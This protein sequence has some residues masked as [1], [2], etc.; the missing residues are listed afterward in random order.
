MENHVEATVSDLIRE[1][2]VTRVL[3]RAFVK[4]IALNFDNRLLR[5][6]FVYHSI[7]IDTEA[8]LADA[9]HSNQKDGK[10]TGEIGQ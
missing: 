5:D 10:T 4:V 7:L 3:E 9:R 2:K 1:S 8:V 6:T